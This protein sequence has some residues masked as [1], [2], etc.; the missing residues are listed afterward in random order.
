MTNL[1]VV[2]IKRRARRRAQADWFSNRNQAIILIA[3]LLGLAMVITAHVDI[4]PN[5]WKELEGLGRQN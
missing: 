1:K 3:V 2:P 4:D 5:F